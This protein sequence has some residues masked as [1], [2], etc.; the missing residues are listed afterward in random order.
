MQIDNGPAFDL[1]AAPKGDSVVMISTDGN[2]VAGIDQ[3]VANESIAITLRLI[4]FALVL[5][6][7]VPMPGAWSCTDFY[8][9]ER[10]A[11]PRVG[12]QRELVE[13]APYSC[14]GPSVQ[15]KD[16]PMTRYVAGRGLL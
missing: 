10:G 1:F 8:I 5:P 12:V 2:Y 4:C 7:L 13:M 14:R 9:F 6:M 11:F 3:R 16:P 15:R